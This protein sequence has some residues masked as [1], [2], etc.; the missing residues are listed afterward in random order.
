MNYL[1]YLPCTQWEIENYLLRNFDFESLD[2]VVIFFGK[3][4]HAKTRRRDIL[5]EKKYDILL[6][7][8]GC[9]IFN[10]KLV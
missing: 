1:L 2:V 4:A 6:Y 7:L 10:S 3:K 5:M 9:F 8:F